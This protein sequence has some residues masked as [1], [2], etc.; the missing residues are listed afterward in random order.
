MLAEALLQF[1][2]VE[3]EKLHR[4]YKEHRAYSKPIDR[5]IERL[6]NLVAKG[7]QIIA[8]I[9]S[10]QQAGL[11]E[12]LPALAIGRADTPWVMLRPTFERTGGV[13]L[14]GIE[15]N[16]GVTTRT[17]VFE[18]PADSWPRLRNGRT[19]Y[20]AMAPHIPP[21]IRPQRGIENYTLIW[22]ATWEPVAPVDPILGRRIGKSDL[23]LVVAQWDLTPIERMVMNSRI[24]S[25]MRRQ[26]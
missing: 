17:K 24:A 22:E 1:D 23:Y 19:F 13:M 12:G 25:S 2:P 7:K 9:G 5:E 10:V 6:A 18:F 8:G 26:R 21:D 14:S 20:R 11:K 3:A 4:K 15:W 16:N